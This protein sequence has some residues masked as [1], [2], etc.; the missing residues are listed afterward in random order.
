[1]EGAAIGGNGVLLHVSVLARLSGFCR[2]I[3]YI[4]V[5]I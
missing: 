5:S 3:Q 2:N 4:N 1:M